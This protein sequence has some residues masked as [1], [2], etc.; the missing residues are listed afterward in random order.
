MNHSSATFTTLFWLR[1]SSFSSL[2][3]LESTSGSP[4]TIY[5]K[6][7]RLAE[8]PGSFPFGSEHMWQMMTRKI[9][10]IG[11]FIELIKKFPDDKLFGVYNF[12]QRNIVV[13]DMELAKRILIKDADHFND[14]PAV[15]T[16]GATKEGDKIFALFLTNLKGE[17]WKKVRYA[18]IIN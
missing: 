17:Q 16:E 5:F 11:C 6:A 7:H 9:S 12:G 8:S 13:N 15:D 2:F 1:F 4:N 18:Y 3:S 14:R 10:A